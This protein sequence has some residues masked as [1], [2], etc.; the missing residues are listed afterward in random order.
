M[1]G[2]NWLGEVSLFAENFSSW[3]CFEK[4]SAPE[5]KMSRLNG[6]LK[7]FLGVHLM[8]KERE[9]KFKAE[10]PVKNM[11]LFVHQVTKLTVIASLLNHLFL[12]SVCFG[13]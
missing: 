11:R 6:L 9:R 8:R 1:T 7:G 2:G 3:I 4:K 12:C 13:V 5:G 10:K